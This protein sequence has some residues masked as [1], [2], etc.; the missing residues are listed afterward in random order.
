MRLFVFFTI[1]I[2]SFIFVP[3]HGSESVGSLP[4]A[5]LSALV[6]NPEQELS[7][8]IQAFRQLYPEMDGTVSRSICVWDPIGKNGPIYNLAFDRTALMMQL[9]ML[10]DLK[11]YTNEGVLTEDL[12]A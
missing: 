4:R 11:A 2:G 10:I 12:K 3:S 7:A 6:M 8:R 5:E 1:V 9:G